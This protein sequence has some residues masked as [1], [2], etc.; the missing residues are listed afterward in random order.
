MPS[1]LVEHQLSQ[2][3][4]WGTFRTANTVGFPR[5]VAT[6]W[7]P[8]VGGARLGHCANTKAK[9]DS[10]AKTQRGLGLPWR[11]LRP[12]HAHEMRRGG[13]HL[14]T[15]ARWAE[16][17]RPERQAGSRQR[18]AVLAVPST[19]KAGPL[20]VRAP[21]FVATPRETRRECHRFAA[22]TAACPAT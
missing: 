12:F 18:P 3:P 16:F 15:E 22:D 11:S 2:R 8:R 5:R 19:P 20:G 4:A 14:P 10:Y 9:R 1:W 17:K 13:A 21:S 7:T 6:A